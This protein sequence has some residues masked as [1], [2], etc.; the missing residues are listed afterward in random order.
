ML[1]GLDDEVDGRGGVEHE[2]FLRHDGPAVVQEEVGHAR[3][4]VVAR[5]EDGDVAVVVAP[6]QGV[7][8][9]AEHFGILAGDI[10]IH[11]K[12]LFQL[13]VDMLAGACPIIV[14]SGAPGKHHL[15]QPG[16]CIGHFLFHVN[17]VVSKAQLIAVLLEKLVVE[18]DDRRG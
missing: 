3:A 6:F 7:A 8:H 10:L 14:G 15:H 17:I 13:L 12:V 5:I 16:F 4:L 18:E 11:G 2:G 1:D 9:S